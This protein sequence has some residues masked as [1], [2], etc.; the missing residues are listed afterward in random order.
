HA[1]RR[2]YLLQRHP[3]HAV[4]PAA[5]RRD[6]QHRAAGGGL[7]HLP[8]LFHQGR[9]HLRPRRTLTPPDTTLGACHIIVPG[10]LPM[11]PR[12]ECGDFAVH[13]PIDTPALPA[14]IRTPAASP[15]PRSHPT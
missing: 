12:R 11:T 6:D 5:R 1:D 9:L 7:L 4:Q 3:L 10:S 2:P 8:A 15:A 13:P 14:P